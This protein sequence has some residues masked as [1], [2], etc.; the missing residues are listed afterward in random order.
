MAAVARRE[1]LSSNASKSRI[2]KPTGWFF[3]HACGASSAFTRIRRSLFA[4]ILAGL[5]VPHQIQIADAQEV[6]D[7]VRSAAT[8]S[9]R[10]T[11][12]SFI[13]VLNRAYR[14]GS[15][16]NPARSA[17]LLE[18]A[19]RHLD[20]SQMSVR[21][22]DYLAPEAALYLKE[23]LDRIDL[24]ARDEVPGRVLATG[25]SRETGIIEGGDAASTSPITIWEVPGT[26]IRIH[27]VAEGPREGEYL[28]T[29][30][31]VQRAEIWYERSRHL[32]YKDNATPGIFDAYALTP[33]RGLNVKLSETL[34]PW[35]QRS[36]G[37]QSVWQWAAAFGTLL[38][39]GVAV[40]LILR[41]AGRIDKR[42]NANHTP[43][44]FGPWRPS[45][46][47]A[48]FIVI[49][50]AGYAEGLIEDYYNLT[51]G[52]LLL[53]AG[54]LS[55]IGHGF[56]AW[57]GFLFV[58]QAAELFASRQGFVARSARTQLVRLIGYFAGA[59]VVTFVAV[60]LAE[61]FGLPALSIVTGLGV[62]GLAVSLAARETLS[63][64][65]GSFVVLIERPYR[66]GDYIEIGADAGTVEEIGIRS[67]K[68]RT[69]S[70]LVVSIPNSSLSAGRI[71]NYGFRR[72]RLSDSVL[73]ISDET[74]P[75]K[76]T[77]FLDRTR[78]IL[79]QNPEVRSEGWHVHLNTV[80]PG[81]LEIRLFYYLDVT[82]WAEFLREQEEILLEILRA[83]DEIGVKIAPTQTVDATFNSA[84]A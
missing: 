5:A 3:M 82:V 60:R 66:I 78:N 33:G 44:S 32:P 59:L 11:L 68:I 76:V 30:Q 22:R 12:F 80:A 79:A 43:D 24:P 47:V 48:L 64:I 37:G 69:L 16:E 49:A 1:D 20:L 31:T 55:F 6:Q 45:L 17:V 18:A 34:P 51:G 65:L 7:V 9:P 70:D 36:F 26:N 29:P 38:I 74:A 63:D 57:L 56:F 27:R 73:R 41:G 61:D 58:S 4:L 21:A 35:I 81:Y 14:V 19:T 53:V 10:A 23:V 13:S 8:T 28:F 77:T 54:L 52:I 50:L 42:L 40:R 46:M 62:G 71:A 72:Y 39:F 25:H 2:D 75:E 15:G 83:A 67:T 84:P